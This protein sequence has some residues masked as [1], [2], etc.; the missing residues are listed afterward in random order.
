MSA[1][2]DMIHWE[3]HITLLVF[4]KIY[5]LNLIMEKRHMDPRWVIC[6]ET[7]DQC[8]SRIRSWEASHDW[9]IA[10]DCKTIETRLSAMGEARTEAMRGWELISEWVWK[11]HF[12]CLNAY[13]FVLII[14]LLLCQISVLRKITVGTEKLY[15]CRFPVQ[16]RLFQDKVQR[17]S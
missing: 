6:Y 2:H 10:T 13:F 5:N 4:S 14:I 16:L 17:K 11:F 3:E 9:G 1:I 8:P 12:A 7:I 15:F